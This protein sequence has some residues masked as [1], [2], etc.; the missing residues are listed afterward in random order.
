METSDEMIARAFER[1]A[2]AAASQPRAIGARLDSRRVHLVLEL[3]SGA[4]L[5]I[6][7]ACLGFAHN[8]DLS[9]VRVEGAGFDLYFPQL[10]EG[11]YIPDL[12]HSAITHQQAA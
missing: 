5:S 7:V 10:D 11:A 4:E 1:G 2:K 8:G 3:A 12:I 6:P 9:G